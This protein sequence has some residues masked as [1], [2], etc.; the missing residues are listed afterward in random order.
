MH[1]LYSFCSGTIIDQANF[2]NHQKA[3]L[4]V[5]AEIRPEGREIVLDLPAWRA[6]VATKK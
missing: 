6:I 3:P 1:F 4:I 2:V 5:L